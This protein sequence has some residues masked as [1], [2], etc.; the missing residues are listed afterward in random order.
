M[1]PALLLLTLCF[2]FGGVATPTTA[3]A[4]DMESE[5][6]KL[7]KQ[8]QEMTEKDLIQR[9]VVPRNTKALCDWSDCV[10]ECENIYNR[11]INRGEPLV[12]CYSRRSRCEETCARRCRQ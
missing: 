4:Q 3:I 1:K 8:I 7:E 6:I 10:K 9:G 5:L 11:C 12:T 2:L